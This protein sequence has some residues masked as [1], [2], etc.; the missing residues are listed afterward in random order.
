MML[1]KY[2]DNLKKGKIFSVQKTTQAKSD[3]VNQGPEM[4]RPVFL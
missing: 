2:C 1:W 3:T 4:T